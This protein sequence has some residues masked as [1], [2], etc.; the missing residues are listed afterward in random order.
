MQESAPSPPTSTRPSHPGRT[1]VARRL[2]ALHRHT[3]QGLH[4]GFLLMWVKTAHSFTVFSLIINA[5][6]AHLCWCYVVQREITEGEK[7]EVDS[8]MNQMQSGK[9]KVAVMRWSCTLTLRQLADSH[10]LDKASAFSPLLSPPPSFFPSFPLVR[11]LSP[12]L[13]HPPSPSPHLSLFQPCLPISHQSA[14]CGASAPNISLSLC[15]FIHTSV[16]I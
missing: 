13:S 2:Q 12:S 4:T 5:L 10:W 9:F 8:G 1:L 3:L 15:L 7:A 16:C 6:N 14:V 11:H